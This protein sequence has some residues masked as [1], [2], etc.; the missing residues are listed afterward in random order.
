MH[1]MG[2]KWTKLRM[3]KYLFIFFGPP[4]MF[5]ARAASASIVE[6]TSHGS[7]FFVRAKWP[8]LSTPLVDIFFILFFL[9]T[10]YIFFKAP[11][12]AWSFSNFFTFSSDQL[13]TFKISDFMGKLL[14]DQALLTDSKNPSFYHFLF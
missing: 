11:I 7:F 13:K 10:F 1:T 12:K 6:L 3:L 8:I 9:Y 5:R 2:A 4:V 14:N